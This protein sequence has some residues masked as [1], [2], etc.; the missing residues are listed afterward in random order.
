[1]LPPPLLIKSRIIWLLWEGL[2]Y[3]WV[4]LTGYE[5]C[6]VLDIHF[7]TLYCSVSYLMLTYFFETLPVFLYLLRSS[8]GSF[9]GVFSHKTPSTSRFFFPLLKGWRPIDLPKICSICFFFALPAAPPPDTSWLWEANLST[10]ISR[11]PAMRTPQSPPLNFLIIPPA[12]KDTKLF[13]SDESKCCQTDGLI[14]SVWW[15]VSSIYRNL[16]HGD[17]KNKIIS[18]EIKLQQLK[19][20]HSFSECI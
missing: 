11:G 7:S 2:M 13:T 12:D 17:V 5:P 18:Q 3:F 20:R 1:M 6:C 4:G 16:W 19:N 10:H 9:F 14:A 15:D 8:S